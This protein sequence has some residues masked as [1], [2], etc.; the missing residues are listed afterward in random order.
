M[1]FLAEACQ[2]ERANPMDRE[3]KSNRYLLVVGTLLAG[4]SL[5]LMAGCQSW[6]SRDKDKNN[7]FAKETK[8]FKELL[9]DPTRPRLVGEVAA[10]LGMAAKHYDA[11]GLAVQLPGTGGVVKPG[12]QR[13]YMLTE[14]RIRNVESPEAVLDAPWSALVKLKVFANPCDQKGETL[15]I[16]V[17]TSTEC[18]ATN[19]SGGAI[20]EAQLREMA[21]LDDR[22]RTSE[23]K[24]TGSGNIVMMPASY[25]KKAEPDLLKGVVIGGGKLIQEQRL[26][27][28]IDQE[29]R[30]VVITKAIEKSI[31]DR[32]FFHEGSR[33]KLVAEGKND[34]HIVIE[35]IPKYKQDPSHF[36]SVLLATGF[37]ESDEERQERLLGCKK[38][39]RNRDTA[40]RAA[41]EL[42][43]LGS[44]EAKQVLIETLEECVVPLADLAR[45][46][47]AFRP[48]C[49]VG[50]SIHDDPLAREALQQLLQESEPELRFGAYLAMKNRNATDLA[51]AGESVGTDFHFTQIPSTTGLIAVSLQKKKEI[52]LFGGSTPV[53]IRETLNPTSSMRLTP[54]MGDQ[55]K[56]TRRE[57]DGT[58][59]HAIVNSDI[60]SVIRGMGT[61]SASYNDLVHTLDVLS[62][63]QAL[64]VPI[65][66]NPRPQA[67]REYTRKNHSTADASAAGQ[68]DVVK[69]DSSSV[70]KKD[71]GPFGWISPA[72]WVKP[73]KKKKSI[74]V[75]ERSAIASPELT[76]EELS[77]VSP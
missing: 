53:R 39:I 22:I 52:V 17:E 41:V 69:V 28:R 73:S 59:S 37:A 57:V 35:T 26:G 3:T 24:A 21:Y 50:L 10:S 23:N 15:D 43:A 71:A 1:G 49:L 64:A 63:K 51:L 61:I 60:V 38:L 70:E 72:S 45:Y 9:L 13:D 58:T 18:L 6:M 5:S 47:P 55:I 65:A 29:F 36:M 75:V 31:N 30:H 20:L 54:V 25:T 11:Y 2:K 40:R 62:A 19:L 74:S 32:F 14:M 34:W 56:L 4:V 48:L 76:D 12:V 66:M 67:G 42:E 46:E 77:L 16:D 27:L 68:V 33:Q 7:E 44:K 8:R